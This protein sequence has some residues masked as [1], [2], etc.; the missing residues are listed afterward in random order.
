MSGFNKFFEAI[1]NK[2]CEI[3]EV[4]SGSGPGS[5]QGHK[6][7][8]GSKGKGKEKPRFGLAVE[9]LK[10]WTKKLVKECGEN[11]IQKWTWGVDLTDEDLR[12]LIWGAD[13]QHQVSHSGYDQDL[14]SDLV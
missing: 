7:S 1:L 10:K 9:E 4:E 5:E 8:S 2:E 6:A 14:P 13:Q 3:C 11:A 12:R